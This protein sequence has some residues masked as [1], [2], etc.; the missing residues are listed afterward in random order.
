[1]GIDTPTNVPRCSAGPIFG[2]KLPSRTPMIIARR[3]HSARNLSS[4]PRPLKADEWTSECVDGSVL[5]STSAAFA[6]SESW[7]DSMVDGSFRD[8]VSRLV[9]YGRQRQRASV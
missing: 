8:G 5:F 9:I 6:V 3:I 2:T 1:M 4:H 7:L